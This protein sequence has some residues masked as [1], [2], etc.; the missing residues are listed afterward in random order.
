MVNKNSFNK[1]IKKSNFSLYFLKSFS[2]ILKKD[3]FFFF[4]NVYCAPLYKGVST[5]DVPLKKSY[6]LVYFFNKGGSND[7]PFISSSRS[8]IVLHFKNI[9]KNLSV[10]ELTKRKGI[11]AFLVFKDSFFVKNKLLVFKRNKKN[12][13]I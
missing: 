10:I 6:E 3:F 2:S 13:Y 12:I 4:N 5:L 1:N 8:F 11:I 7:H 9:L